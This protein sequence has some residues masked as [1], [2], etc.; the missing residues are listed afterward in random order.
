MS[1]S[2]SA[3]WLLLTFCLLM[4]ALIV[5]IHT[6]SFSFF[7]VPWMHDLSVGRGELMLA[8]SCSAIGITCFSP[9]G[10][11]LVDRF[12]LRALLICA[13][14]L[15]AAGLFV[16]SQAHSAWVIVAVYTVLLPI[17]MSLAGP[18]AAQTMIARSF[19]EGRGTALGINALGLSIGAFAIPILVTTL[20]GAY[21]WR[22]AMQVL[23]AAVVVLIALP[24]LVLPIPAQD[25]ASAHGH[26]GIDWR[27]MRSPSALLIGF[28]YLIP[29]M[30]FVA[31]LHNLGAYAQDLG[32]P[33]P[34]V[35]LLVSV[36]AIAMA[37]GKITVGFSSDRVK[38]GVIYFTLLGMT[39]AG[40]VLSASG[41]GLIAL[42][43]GICLL[44]ISGAGILPFVNVM[45]LRAY[46]TARFGSATGVVQAIGGLAGIGPSIIGW[47]RDS[48]GNYSIAFCWLLL[49]LVPSGF[50]FF[51]LLRRP[52]SQLPVAAAT[53]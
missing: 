40:I 42:G 3:R 8:I 1:Q 20:L 15:F 13:A 44:G 4:Q 12:P 6:Y 24:A 53:T 48:S 29:L 30:C 27:L 32:L 11:V 49:P 21:D 17:G 7:I 43:A 31:V 50:A 10:G 47:I 25:Q 46:G 41:L 9:V 14:L 16:I 34:R 23:S 52:G 2:K 18:L 38:P 35:A 19:T 26:R 45:I 51:M 37:L 5:G 33:Q 28:T 22:I 39:A 36:A